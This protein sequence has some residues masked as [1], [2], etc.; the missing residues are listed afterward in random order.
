MTPPTDTRT[1]PPLIVDV[2]SGAVLGDFAPRIGFAYQLRDKGDVV[3]RGGIGVFYD[4]INMNPFLDFRPPITAA[5]GL[6][7]N[8]IG[9]A[10]VSTCTVV[11][12]PSRSDHASGN[13]LSVINASDHM[14]P[15][16][17]NRPINP[18]TTGANTNCPNDAPALRMPEAMPRLCSGEV[19]VIMHRVTYGASSLDPATRM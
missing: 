2:F 9:A 15:A 18:C 5:Q 14:A 8:P 19:D 11:V 13:A 12:A 1:W 17:L 4:Q 6:Q 10:P 7:G 16:Q 3:I